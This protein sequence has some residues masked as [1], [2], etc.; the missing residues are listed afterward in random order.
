M[1]VFA[2]PQCRWGK[3]AANEQ[4]KGRKGNFTR[5][6]RALARRPPA[7]KEDFPVQDKGLILAKLCSKSPALVTS[8]V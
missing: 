7:G 8:L 6:L 2:D 1:L 3:C 5:G 4:E